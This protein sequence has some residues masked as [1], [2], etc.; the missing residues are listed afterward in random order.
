MMVTVDKIIE[1]IEDLPSPDFVVQKIMQVA[2]NPNASAKEVSQVISADPSLSSR[3]LKIANS[4]YYGI[5]RK[6]SVL[7]EA[8][9]ILGFKTV[10]NL[11][12]SVFTYDRF[13]K[14]SN[15][16]S[17]IDR[18]RLWRHF[19]TTAVISETLASIV[20]Y[21]VKEELFIAG[22]LHDIGK[23]VYDVITPKI[24]ASVYEVASKTKKTFTDV[25]R[26]LEIPHHGIIGAKLLEKWNFPDLIITTVENHHDPS[27]VRDSVYSEIVSMVHISNV[28]ANLLYP[29]DSLSFGDPYLD[30]AALNDVSIKPKGILNLLEKSKEKIS[31]A[32]EFLDM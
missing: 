6:I 17:S 31:K 15:E 20:G 23:I 29:G 11:A 27:S 14:G 28:L 21:P 25:E 22:L 30:P 9:M 3:I 32:Q 2:S 8:V 1:K 4:A 10:R 26:D 16:Q 18:K 7:S 12:L 13:F 19:V 5:P 24:L